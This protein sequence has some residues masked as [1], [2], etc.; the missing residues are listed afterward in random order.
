MRLFIYGMESSGASTFCLFLGQRPGSVAVVDLWSHCLAPPLEVTAPIVL[1]ATANTTYWAR[2]HVASFRPDGSILFLRDPVAVYRSLTKYEYANY[3][4]TVEEKLA[5]FDQEYSEAGFDLV[6]RYED[7][8]CR[9]PAL[10][11]A[12]EGLGWPCHMGFY[13]LPRRI[14][15]IR[16]TNFAESPWLER[17]F[18]KSW[19]FGNFKGSSVSGDFAG[20]DHPPEIAAKVATL[21]PNL[22][23]LYAAH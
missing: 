19:G 20:T 16:R 15:R 10:L 11:A 18:D 1:K 8:I 23:A 7:F 2:D 14:E 22:T 13:D 6:L 3:E 9:D 17:E 21:C 5:R 12:V 4:G